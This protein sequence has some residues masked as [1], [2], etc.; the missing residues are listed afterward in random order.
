MENLRSVAYSSIKENI[1]NCTYAPGAFL[2]TAFIVQELG[3]SRTP[4]REAITKL[5]QEGLVQIVSQKGVLIQNVT[6]KNI[7]DVYTTR[8]MTDD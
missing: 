4:V 7:R 1:I 6:L 8:Q 3:M 5:E 2:D